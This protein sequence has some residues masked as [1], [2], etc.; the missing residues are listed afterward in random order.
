M[1]SF[2]LTPTLR[3]KYSHPQLIRVETKALR[4]EV[5]FPKSHSQKGAELG[6]KRGSVISNSIFN[7]TLVRS[8]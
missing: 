6:A 5:T 8:V 3:A 2:N 7:R 1:I 4:S